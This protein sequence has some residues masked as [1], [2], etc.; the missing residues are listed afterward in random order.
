MAS[1]NGLT[2]S[3]LA[4][5]VSGNGPLPMPS[6]SVNDLYAGT[7]AQQIAQALSGGPV[8]STKTDRGV[9]GPNPPQFFDEGILPRDQTVYRTPTARQAIEIAAPAAA[10]NPAG[11]GFG[12]TK[13]PATRLVGGVLPE[14]P[15]GLKPTVA[16]I[17]VR[18]GAPQPA[19]QP[20][21]LGRG[22]PAMAWEPATPVGTP[23]AGDPWAGVR[24]GRQQLPN[25]PGMITGPARQQLPSGPI[26]PAAA[27]HARL[28]AQQNLQNPAAQA[29]LNNGK[30]SYTSSKGSGVLAV[31]ALMPTKTISGA[32]RNTYGD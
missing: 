30:S 19:Y 27:I 17:L 24:I 14:T 5:L 29:A 10:P 22:Q 11:F 12:Y 3:E 28:L 16:E 23:P 25:A 7:A 15:A 31:N 1:M 6:Y 9:L 21:M 20:G 26:R 8:Q 4:K 32:V 2:Q 13:P 18:G